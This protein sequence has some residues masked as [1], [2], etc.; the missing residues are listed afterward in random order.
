[1]PISVTS[2]FNEFEDKCTTPGSIESLKASGEC[3]VDKTTAD[4]SFDV[5]IVSGQNKAQ[6]YYYQFE[7]S[8]IEE[9]DLRDVTVYV[10]GKKT[11]VDL[12]KGSFE[13]SA[14]EQKKEI[15]LIGT[16]DPGRQL[17]GS[18]TITLTMALDEEFT[19]GVIEETA[20]INEFYK[21]TTPGSIESLKASGECSVDKTTADYSFDV[22]IVSGQNKA[23]TYY[24]QFEGSDIEEV[25]YG[26]S[27]FM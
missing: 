22:V 11:A 26:T 14:G 24:Y 13:L 6:T 21:C 3:S 15:Q 4:Y 25:I 23:Q 8:D 20:K 2:Q 19:D 16:L 18:E 7:G 5:V 27:R 9:G 12:K 1:M 10:N 17:K